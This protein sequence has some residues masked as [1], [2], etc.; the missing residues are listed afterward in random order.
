MAKI[1]PKQLKYLLFSHFP[2]F[3]PAAWR[4][5]RQ[6]F[7]NLENFWEAEETDWLK[8]GLSPEHLKNFLTFR[9]K[10]LEEEFSNLSVI[11]ETEA[12]SFLDYDNPDYP[13]LLKEI[14]SPPALLYYQGNLSALDKIGLAIVGSRRISPYAPKVLRALLPD[15]LIYN[16]A[17]VSGLAL[18]VDSLAHELS[19]A[20]GRPT[21]AV[22]GSGLDRASFYPPANRSLRQNILDQG[23]LLLSEFPPRTPPR[24]QNFP[25][26]NRLIAGLSQATLVVEAAPKSGA[27]ITAAYAL[28]F[29][30]EVLAI[31]GALDN[32]NSQGPNR[33]IQQ[34][35]RTILNSLDLLEA[36]KIETGVKKNKP[37]HRGKTLL[38]QAGAN[39]IPIVEFA[40]ENEKIIYQIIAQAETEG[41]RSINPDE[42]VLRSSLDTSSVNS[43]LSI[44]EIKKLIKNDR[45]VYQL[46]H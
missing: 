34:G 31:P 24:R 15:L 46:N 25:Q 3:G 20:A 19:L 32:L 4:K 27:L 8:S 5:I 16:I 29:N 33:L 9:K 10:F 40:S 41:S 22:L 14:D 30:R 13:R 38:N 39:L 28:D 35:A 11:L 6:Y 37:G 43:T 21:I 17:T 42:I 26:R 7:S 36:L 12:I 44:M 1:S 23:G 45:G 2:A 18:G